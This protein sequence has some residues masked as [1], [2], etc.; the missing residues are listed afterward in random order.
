MPI[1]NSEPGSG[2]AGMALW[3]AGAVMAIAGAK[4]PGS[5]VKIERKE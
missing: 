5:R 1:G 2:N 4:I 3:G